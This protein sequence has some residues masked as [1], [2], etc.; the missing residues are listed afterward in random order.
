MA[1]RDVGFSGPQPQPPAPLPT[2]REIRVEFKG[3]IYQCD[4]SDEVFAEVAK[5]S[6]SLAEDL[7]VVTSH[8]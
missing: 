5:Y 8:P 4:C 7:G 2:Q 6:A 3:T 1:N